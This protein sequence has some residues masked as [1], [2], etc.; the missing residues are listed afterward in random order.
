MQK[1][2]ILQRRPMPKPEMEFRI[3]N[4]ATVDS[5]RV[6]NQRKFGVAATRAGR[7]MAK[8]KFPIWP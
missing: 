4:D 6:Y 3:R 8:R 7:D 5:D 2:K 1:T